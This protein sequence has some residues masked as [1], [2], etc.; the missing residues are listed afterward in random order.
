M[1]NK[2]RWLVL[3][4]VILA[5][6][7]FHVQ[8]Q[9]PGGVVLRVAHLVADGPQVDVFLDGAR[10]LEAVAFYRITDH[11]QLE[12][13][14]HTLTFTRT[15]VSADRPLIPPITADFEADSSHIL[16]LIGL[17]RNESVKGILIDE[18]TLFR[19]TNLFASGE[20]TIFLN[21]LSDSP[22][23]DVYFNDRAVFTG[24]AYGDYDAVNFPL[25]SVMLRFIA[26]GSGRGTLVLEMAQTFGLPNNTSL[27]ALVGSYNEGYDSFIINYSPLD[28]FS[29]LD[30]FSSHPAV[31]FNTLISAAEIAA[32]A[33]TLREQG[34]YTLFAP[35]DSA[36]RRLG[37]SPLKNA[38]DL[39][40]VLRAHIVPERLTLT[41]IFERAG[42]S[43]VARLI[44]LYGDEITV[45]LSGAG[46]TLNRAVNLTS[47]DY[48]AYNGVV[49]LIDGVLQLSGTSSN[50]I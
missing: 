23:L 35:P 41:D 6:G 12:P 17:V 34:P 27:L 13:G 49:H 16:A 40:A 15:G 32:L 47:A 45:E 9:Q 37:G 18:T 36:F 31:S 42:R 19:R 5:T 39:A 11:L 29:Y 7:V 2:T 25:E 1:L 44:N 33:S 3:L 26:P 20:R 21:G 4:L 24:L 22:P 48:M 50:S 8:A 38:S 28:L 30:G 14:R 46:I 43:G 10:V